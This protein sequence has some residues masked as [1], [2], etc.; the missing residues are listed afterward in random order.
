MLL[1]VVSVWCWFYGCWR[2]LVYVDWWRLV[3]VAL[4]I[5]YVWFGHRGVY[6][7]GCGCVVVWTFR[8]VVGLLCC[9]VVVCVWSFDLLVCAVLFVSLCYGFG[10]WVGVLAVVVLC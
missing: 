6:S 7:S 8:W 3:V 10:L 4:W 1:I 2:C 5:L 9:I